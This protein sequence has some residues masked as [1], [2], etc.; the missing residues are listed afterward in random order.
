MDF[1]NAIEEMKLG[2]E[3]NFVLDV[4][5]GRFYVIANYTVISIVLYI[6]YSHLKQSFTEI[7]F[8]LVFILFLFYF[9]VLITF[10]VIAKYTVISVVFY[11]HLKQSFTEI[12][13]YSAFILF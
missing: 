8:Y 9:D 4:L 6:L 5:I 13:F 10:Y 3:W 12:L 2:Q 7:L 1:M 11:S